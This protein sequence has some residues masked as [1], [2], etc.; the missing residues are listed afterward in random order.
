[1]VQGSAAMVLLFGTFVAVFIDFF[2][3]SS[4]ELGNQPVAFLL[5]I[6]LQLLGSKIL[7]D[8]EYDRVT[9][10]IP[11][12]REPEHRKPPIETL[13]CQSRN[14]A[15]IS[16]ITV[17]ED[18]HELTDKGGQSP[19]SRKSSHSSS[20]YL[21][22]ASVSTPLGDSE[23][24]DDAL[25]ESPMLECLYEFRFPL[26]HFFACSILL[27]S[28]LLMTSL[29]QQ[30]ADITLSLGTTTNYWLR[31]IYLVTFG[32]FMSCT[33]LAYYKIFSNSCDGDWLRDKQVKIGISSCFA[34]MA[35]VFLSLVYSERSILLD[36]LAPLLAS[37]GDSSA[38]PLFIGEAW[39]T[40]AK[41]S[42][43]DEL[44]RDELDSIAVNVTVLYGGDW[45]CPGNPDQWCEIPI[46]A[47][48]ECTFYEISSEADDDNGEEP[49]QLTA[50]EY[51]SLRYY[52]SGAGD[53]EA[54]NY[55]Q[56]PSSSYWDRPSEYIVGSCNDCV[57]EPDTWVWQL[58]QRIA[59]SNYAVYLGLGACLCYLGWPLLE[60]IST[61][62]SNVAL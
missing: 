48:L 29:S 31:A 36:Q 45:A 22:M 16:D 37:Q 13:D 32:F 40:E 33:S 34:V 44:C 21:S 23:S 43:Q 12:Q 17:S 24:Y 47:R 61:F 54:Y 39:V 15:T 25:D 55:E 20:D 41:L 52:G 42:R 58:N 49:A 27:S 10:T 5:A 14:M 46:K 19:T 11:V 62:R 7:V 4:G 9:K 53:D 28:I 50:Q 59:Q 57:A 2:T 26:V 30:I 51:V 6:L 3:A 18:Y 60:V 35:L 1:M 8:L 38:Q 56:Q